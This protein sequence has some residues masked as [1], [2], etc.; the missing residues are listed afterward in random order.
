MQR[1]RKGRLAVG[2]QRSQTHLCSESALRHP[3]SGRSLQPRAP[4]P[5]SPDLSCFQE[6]SHPHSHRVCSPG[7]LPRSDSA[8]PLRAQGGPS[9]GPLSSSLP[10]WPPPGTQASPPTVT[11]RPQTLV[12][13]LAL[14]TPGIRVPVPAVSATGPEIVPRLETSGAWA[15]HPLQG[16]SGHHLQTLT[17]KAG[18]SLALVTGPQG[19]GTEKLKADQPCRG[20]RTPEF[21]K[22]ASAQNLRQ[23]R[24]L[25]SERQRI[26]N[27]KTLREKASLT[28]TTGTGLGSQAPGRPAH[29]V[30]PGFHFRPRYHYSRYRGPGA[31]HTG[32]WATSWDITFPGRQPGGLRPPLSLSL[33]AKGK[34]DSKS[35][36]ASQGAPR[37]APPPSIHVAQSIA[38]AFSRRLMEPAVFI[39]TPCHWAPGSAREG[40]VWAARWFS[41]L[42]PSPGGN[43]APVLHL[44]QV[45]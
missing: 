39:L 21:S 29:S 9:A 15:P 6:P 23:T 11:P 24:D 34:R 7:P 26:R 38:L 44:S 12:L 17:G 43:L 42:P 30:C 10:V 32:A 2:P 22:G 1:L 25:S 5:L 33:G 3:K 4:L 28:P 41:R 36:T 13:L 20:T 18:W 35:S 45:L 14:Q 8:C 27:W 31:S 19:Q 40:G 16:R 37:P